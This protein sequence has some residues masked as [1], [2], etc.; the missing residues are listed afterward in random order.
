MN[1]EEILWMGDIEPWMDES[2]IM[3]SFFEFGFKP[4]SIKIIV[5]TKIN[6]NRNFG[7]V[8]FKNVQEAN[9]ALFKLNGKKI[10]KTNSY[11]KLNLTKKSSKNKKIIYVG[12]LSNNISDKELYDFFK[13]KYSSVISASIISDNGISRGYGFVHFI[14]EKEYEKCLKEM[15][16][17]YIGNDKIDVRKKSIIEQNNKNLFMPFFSNNKFNYLK[18][19]KVNNIINENNNYINKD[20]SII[21]TKDKLNLN[22]YNNDSFSDNRELLENNDNITLYK[23]YK[24]LQENANKMFEFYKNRKKI[25]EIPKIILYYCSNY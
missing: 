3:K 15:D 21:S 8:K 25:D 12:N 19:F 16:G 6:K 11:F 7:Y 24:K 23:L 10:P 13:S 18:S 9:N 2:T 17:S 22:A 14:D 5:D 1:I 20:Y 4:L